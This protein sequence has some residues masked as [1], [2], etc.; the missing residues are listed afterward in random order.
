[1]D[2]ADASLSSG[3]TA[4][5]ASS[6]SAGAFFVSFLDGVSAFSCSILADVPFSAP[7]F[8]GC[9]SGFFSGELS[10][11]NSL[12]VLPTSFA[13]FGSLT[14]V[15]ASNA[16]FAGPDSLL[17]SMS[18]SFL[19]SLPSMALRKFSATP[20]GRV[21]PRLFSRELVRRVS[22]CSRESPSRAFVVSFGSCF[23]APSDWLNRSLCPSPPPRSR[24]PCP[25]S[26]FP[27]FRG[28][29]LRF[30]ISSRSR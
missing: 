11:Q 5:A 4:D 27:V 15:T 10:P 22:F 3:A 24:S 18:C 13:S 6:V 9:F 2:C 17:V 1:M 14:P 25:K 30:L 19:E 28:A 20:S 16:A 21:L 26:P 8:A 7:D 23:A 29:S 12:M